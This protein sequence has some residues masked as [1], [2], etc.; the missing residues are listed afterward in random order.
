[1]VQAKRKGFKA[2]KIYPWVVIICGALFYCYQ[3]IILVSPGVMQ[4]DVMAMLA[5]DGTTFG[6]IV[7][8]YYWGYSGMQ[9][10]LGIALDKLGPRYLLSLASLVCALSTYIFGLAKNVPIAIIARFFMGVGASCGFIGTLKLGTLWFP[11]HR[12]GTAMGIAYVFGTLGAAIGG[13][14]LS[15]H[16]QKFGW[17]KTFDHIAIAGVVIAFLIFF[18][19]DNKGPYADS[20]EEIDKQHIFSGMWRVIRTPQAWLFSIIGALMY[21]PISIIGVAWGI[22]LLKAMY[23]AD[24]AVVAPIIAAMFTGGAIGAPVFTTLSDY[25]G[26]R[27]KPLILGV[28]LCTIIWFIVLYCKDIPIPLMYALFFA[29]GFFYTTKSL[30]FASNIEIMPSEHSGITLGFTNMIVMLTGVIGHP[31]VGRMLD[32]SA[33]SDGRLGTGAERYIIDDYRFALL[34]VPI[35]IM[36]CLAL[37]AFLDE[38]HPRH[39]MLRKY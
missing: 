25:I 9:L 26:S 34:I 2:T 1:M 21:L 24:E 32:Y 39:R 10:P 27:K 14:P 38:T 3:F 5:I 23:G 4:D 15:W 11:P 18:V 19:T 7:G 35:G 16:I 20:E 36:I 31:I 13:A 28:I 22:P 17:V 30:T 33:D 12:F 29:G 8:F 37:I 6:F